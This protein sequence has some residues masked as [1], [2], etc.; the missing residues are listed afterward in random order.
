MPKTHERAYFYT[1][2]YVL[3]FMDDIVLLSSILDYMG[4][5]LDVMETLCSINELTINED[6]KKMMIKR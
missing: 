3:L 2:I 1:P 6:K 5:L 4:H